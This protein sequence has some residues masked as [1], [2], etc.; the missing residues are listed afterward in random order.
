MKKTIFF[1]FGLCMLF[2]ASGARAESVINSNTGAD[3]KNRTEINLENSFSVEN[4]NQATV[5]N[6]S[7]I[8]VNT[9]DNEAESS[10]GN[11]SVTSGDIIIK[12]SISNEIE[13]QVSQSPTPSP[14]VVPT[15]TPA[16]IEGGVGGAPETLATIEAGVGGLPDQ[17]PGVGSQVGLLSL[18]ASFA[19]TMV[20]AIHRYKKLA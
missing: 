4:D 15:P 13:F 8:E 20:Y 16:I 2:F 14:T 19:G 6:Y 5:D 10:T 18:L 9:G 3:S 11:G 7:R 12:E 1:M 17:L